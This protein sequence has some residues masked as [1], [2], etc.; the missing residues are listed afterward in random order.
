MKKEATAI[1]VGEHK[2]GY[3]GQKNGKRVIFYRKGNEVQFVVS[4]EDLIMDLLTGP[5]EE[6]HDAQ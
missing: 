1:Y 6:L 2:I 4:S 5:C 3:R